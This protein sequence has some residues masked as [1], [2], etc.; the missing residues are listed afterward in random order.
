MKQLVINASVIF[1][2]DGQTVVL[3]KGSA[4]LSKL[5]Q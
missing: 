3:S 4:Y 2:I 1:V 5:M